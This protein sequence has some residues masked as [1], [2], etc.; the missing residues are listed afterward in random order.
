MDAAQ[1]LDRDLVDRPLAVKAVSFF[2]GEMKH[3]VPDLRGEHLKEIFLRGHRQALLAGL[4]D[5]KVARLDI[6][7]YDGGERLQPADL[8]LH[9]AGALDSGPFAAGGHAVAAFRPVAGG[10]QKQSREKSR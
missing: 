1:I 6:G 2:E 9:D 7:Y 5:D 3:A 4:L 10:E 8:G